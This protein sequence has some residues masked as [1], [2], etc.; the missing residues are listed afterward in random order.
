[1]HILACHLNVADSLV[2]LYLAM[3]LIADVVFIYDDLYVAFKWKSSILCHFLSVMIM[4][5]VELS[6]LSTFLIAVDRFMLIVWHPYEKYGLKI[7][8][9]IVGILICWCISAILP[10]LFAS[11]NFSALANNACILIGKSQPLA[12]MITYFVLNLIVFITIFVVYIAVIKTIKQS[13]NVSQNKNAATASVMLRLGA[14]IITNFLT[15]FTMGIMGIISLAGVPLFSSVE[16]LVSL[17]IFPVN[18]IINPVINT[19]STKQFLTSVSKKK[20][21]TLQDVNSLRRKKSTLSCKRS[22]RSSKML[23]KAPQNV[24]PE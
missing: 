8:V 9:S 11:L 16:A 3:L 18:A 17:A 20:S 1:V 23:P 5:S 22:L 4:L 10:T 7:G 19:F 13:A 21:T 2:A 15:W 6:T 14:V 24:T 12:Y